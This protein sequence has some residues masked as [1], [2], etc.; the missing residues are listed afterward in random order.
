M[1]SSHDDTKIDLEK[2][3]TVH[4]SGSSGKRS[5]EV[6]E[7]TREQYE[8]LFLEPG[9]RAPTVGKLSHQFGNPT[10]L[11][12]I[13][14]C[15]C[16]LPTACVLLQWGTAD[17]SSLIALIGPFYYLGGL[18]MI[19]SGIME[20]ILGNTFP[21]V[22]FM[23]FGGFW[24]SFATLN[25]PEHGIAAA[26]SATGGANSPAL[27]AGVLFYLCGWGVVL[28]IYF[29]ASLR[30]NVVFAFMFF[31]VIFL[32]VCLATA[33]GRFAIGDAALGI[34]F[35]KAAGGFALVTTAGGFYLAF[36]M[37]FGCVELPFELPVGDL[38]TW[39]P[40]KPKPGAP[41]RD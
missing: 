2:G 30:T 24:L 39:I 14:F 19:I 23:T 28:L 26:F 15:L 7:L 34:T 16:L 31:N 11:A 35:M 1:A 3:I 36:T 27:N 4:E 17:T 25:D 20:W 5:G 18:C 12:I 21:M 13:A 6:H 32:L 37:M 29:I 22:V 9:G 33:Y 41:K 8:R 40:S 10:P 38:S